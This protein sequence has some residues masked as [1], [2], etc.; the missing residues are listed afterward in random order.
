MK[1]KTRIVSICIGALAAGAICLGA[2]AIHS[3]QGTSQLPATAP[4]SKAITV[5]IDNF[6]FKP[7]ELTINAGSTV[8]WINHDDV[9]HTA[10][11]KGKSPVFDSKML[12][13]DEQFSFTFKN[14]GAYTYYCK[15][16]P[17]M[18]ATIVVK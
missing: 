2:N 14:P 12:D 18:S 15:V 10:T 4:A 9:P 3:D 7:R 13:T 6:N 11:G 1:S 8:T 17:H 5:E 16:H